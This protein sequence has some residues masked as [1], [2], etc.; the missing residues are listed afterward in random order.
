[1]I[2][3]PNVRNKFPT[4]KNNKTLN[5]SMRTTTID[6]LSNTINQSINQPINQKL[7]KLNSVDNIESQTVADVTVND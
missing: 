3:V 7:R 4:I 5:K 2:R 6:F 1:M